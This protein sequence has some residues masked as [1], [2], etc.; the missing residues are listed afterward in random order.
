MHRTPCVYVCVGQEE[1]DALSQ[2][3]QAQIQHA[4]AGKPEPLDTLLVRHM[5]ALT[6]NPDLILNLT[7]TLALI[8][9]LAPIPTL[10]D[11]MKVAKELE[12]VRMHIAERE[13]QLDKQ[14]S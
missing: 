13:S 4:R 7:L 14:V 9:T 8:L 6:L 5:P 12:T 10:T 3:S 1:L 2:Q 11:H